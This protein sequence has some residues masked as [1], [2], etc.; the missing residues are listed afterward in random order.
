ML[1][2]LTIQ[3]YALIDQI[4]LDLSGGLTILTG[5]TG[6][7]KSIIIDALGLLLGERATPSVVRTGST[8]AV[9]EGVFSVQ[10][11]QGI[12]QL[13]REHDL[14]PSS[15]LIVRREVSTRTT[16]RCF[17]NDTPVPLSVLKDAGDL[18][19]DLHGQHEHQSLLRSAT[20]VEFLDA[21]GGLGGERDAYQEAFDQLL[22][23]SRRLD[24]LRAEERGLKEKED[25]CRFQLHEIDEVR[26]DPEEETQLLAEIRIL[27]N[28][29]KIFSGTQEL[30]NIL[31][32]GERS[33]YDLMT[34]VHDRFQVL[35][36]FDPRFT[37]MISESESVRAVV[38][39]LARS[40][41]E[42]VSRMD[43]RPERVEEVR[44]RLGNLSML[45]K[46]YGGSIESVVEYRDKIAETLRHSA[47]VGGEM[48]R[49]ASEIG[50][51]RTRCVQL[52]EKLSKKRLIAAR[53]L[54]PDV[55]G[56]LA[57]LGMPN[58]RFTVAVSREELPREHFHPEAPDQ[59]LWKEKRYRMTKM[60]WDRI[61]FLV[62]ANPGEEVKPLARIASGGEIS[63]IMLALKS[64]L[65]RHDR[66][67]VVVFD[68]IDAGV[69][70]RVAQA[71][72]QS[73][74]KLAGT[75]QV[76]VI[77]HLAQIAG[78]ADTHFAVSK[79]DDGERTKTFIR[80]LGDEDR[81][82][83]VARLLSGERITEAGLKG[84]RELMRN[85]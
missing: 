7:G 41:R 71:V 57:E 60:G 81:V 35:S 26:P 39:E 5:E 42:Y 72:G 14:D 51:A 82:L 54:E 16:G 47:S 84:A 78:L 38:E 17:L 24:E 43:F 8:K 12:A 2:S 23:L 30:S 55:T 4:R 32:D 46:K 64:I 34:T 63:R 29:E 69:S 44:E 10:N 40:L 76:V 48:E 67:P 19:V 6:A 21:F 73:L 9:V 66:L 3:N 68:E 18:L 62:S 52:A 37:A 31:Y 50:E 11:H 70:G 28:A 1:L 20:H 58:A 74:K 45:K 77:T 59:V 83:E 36:G 13:L 79:S 80:K 61:E 65:A 56:S 75:I 25:L 15:E 22:G 27:D 85:P 53:K 33:L 49:I